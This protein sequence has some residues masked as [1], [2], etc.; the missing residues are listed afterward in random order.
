MVLEEKL[1]SIGERIWYKLMISRLRGDD[2]DHDV[3]LPAHHHPFQ[4]YKKANTYS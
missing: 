4:Y 3:I 1:K 2:L